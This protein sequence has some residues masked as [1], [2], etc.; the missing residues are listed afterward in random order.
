MTRDRNFSIFKV[1]TLQGK[2]ISVDRIWCL[3]CY[4]PWGTNK[5]VLIT[6]DLH[7]ANYEHC[8]IRLCDRVVRAIH[9]HFLEIREI[10]PQGWEIRDDDATFVILPSIGSTVAIQYRKYPG[11]ERLFFKFDRQDMKLICQAGIIAEM[12]R[13]IPAMTEQQWMDISHNL[14]FHLYTLVSNDDKL[15]QNHLQALGIFLGRPIIP[16]QLPFGIPTDYYNNATKHVL[17]NLFS[18]K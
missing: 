4:N 7:S 13:K 11:A 1:K 8:N 18:Y 16:F 14:H 10:P 5:D 15:L 2:T 17:H 12:V 6:L 9:H 3:D